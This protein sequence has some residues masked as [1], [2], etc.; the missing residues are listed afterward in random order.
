MAEADVTLS[1]VTVVKAPPPAAAPGGE[2][3]CE[4][5]RAT[6]GDCYRTRGHRALWRACTR[7]EAR[8]LTHATCH[9]RST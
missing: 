2:Y 6:G 1:A 8:T 3:A 4:E 7:D 5:V 9:V